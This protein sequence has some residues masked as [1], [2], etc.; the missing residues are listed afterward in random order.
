M[1]NDE[2]KESSG[3]KKYSLELRVNKNHPNHLGE[4]EDNEE[5]DCSVLSDFD[6]VSALSV[7]L[8]HETFNAV[9]NQALLC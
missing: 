1:H 3:S 9:H 8:L 7:D 2:H 5:N 6:F 4:N